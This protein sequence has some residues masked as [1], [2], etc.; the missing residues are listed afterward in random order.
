MV[1]SSTGELLPEYA[2]PLQQEKKFVPLLKTVLNI[3]KFAGEALEENDTIRAMSSQIRSKETQ[4]LLLMLLNIAL[5]TG[6]LILIENAHWIDSSSWSLA[7]GIA[8]DFKRSLLLAIVMRPI[9]EKSNFTYTQ[10]IHHPHANF[11][12]LSNL[13][14]EDTK[15][16]I[17]QCVQEDL[18]RQNRDLVVKKI[19]TKVTQQI[20]NKSSGEEKKKICEIN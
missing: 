16:L 18:N 19:P 15:D 11:I 3:K 20:Y 8:N 17:E 13:S 4:R 1:N 7:L 2:S 5:K 14:E 12:S 10:I 9:P 6:S